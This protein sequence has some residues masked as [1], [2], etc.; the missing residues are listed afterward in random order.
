MNALVPVKRMSR[1][2]SRPSTALAR[3]T[4]ASPMVLENL[5]A[6]IEQLQQQITTLQTRPPQVVMPVEMPAQP[7][8][9]AMPPQPVTVQPIETALPPAPVSPPEPRTYRV[10]RSSLLDFFD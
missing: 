2:S 5:L 1:F 7:A 9:M 6:S 3:G 10:R 4:P 8:P